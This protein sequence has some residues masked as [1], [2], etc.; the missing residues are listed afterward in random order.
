M[1]GTAPVALDHAPV[2]IVA[3]ILFAI[4][5]LTGALIGMVWPLPA[6]G[7]P[8]RWFAGGALIVPALLFGIASLVTMRRAGTSPNPHVA[9]AALVERGPY[10]MTR[11]PMYVS[12]VLI[13]S[14]VACLFR[15]TWVL[16][17]MPLAVL[18]VDRWVIAPEERY[19]LHRFGDAYSAYCAR[20]RRWI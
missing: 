14:G 11:N 13:Y 19:L 12:M 5:Y 1:N 7:S 10:R 17:L 9:S 2:R 8:A 6:P 4:E 18:A 15:A 16:V 3:P 20:V